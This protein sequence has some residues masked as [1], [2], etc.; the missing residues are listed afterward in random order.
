M[1]DFPM[2][3]GASGMFGKSKAG[4][5]TEDMLKNLKS[6]EKVALNI[7]KI[8][9]RI[10]GKQGGIGSSGG[11]SGDVGAQMNQMMNR[12]TQMTTSP[13][14]GL[15]R[16]LTAGKYMAAAGAVGYGMLPSTTDAVAQRISAQSVASLSGGRFNAQQVIAG[17]NQM[18]AG[19]MTGAYSAQNT[20]AL[21]TGNG[22]IAG[23]TGYGNIMR[24]VGGESAL[25]GM[26][27]EQVG[28]AWAS[29]NG[30]S[31]LSVGVRLRDATGNIRNTADISNDLYRRI[32]GNR[33]LTAEQ[34]AQALNPNSHTYQSILR[35]AGGN[36]QLAQMLATNI[37][38]QG[39]HGGKRLP[40][41]SPDAIRNNILGLPKDDP[42]RAVSKFFGSEA[43]NLQ[44]NGNGL[45]GGYDKA[46]GIA[47]G[48]N[49]GFASLS[50]SVPAVANAFANL[51]GILETLP[52]AGNA[53]ATASGLLGAGMHAVGG[54]ASNALQLYAA[55]KVLK[56][57]G[58]SGG[59]GAAEAAV[60]ARA[61]S[62][63]AKAM[64]LGSKAM[65]L[66][67][68]KLLPGLGAAIDAWD[69]HNVG[70]NDSGFS[71][72]HML[73]A[74]LSGG[75]A[76]AVIGSV[77]PGFGTLAGAGVGSVLNM[78]N[79]A[80]SHAFGGDMSGPSVG[81]H[82]AGVAPSTATPGSNG[83]FRPA[84]GPNTAMYGQKPKNNSYWQWKGYHTG[85]DFGVHYKPVYSYKSGTVVGAGMNITG[86]NAYGNTIIVD[87]GGHQSLY[88]HLSAINVRKG[89]KVI[90][91][92]NI[93]TSG[94][95]GTGAAMG[96]HLHFEIRKGGNPI[97]PLSFL[98]GSGIA[99]GIANTVRGAANAVGNAISSATHTVANWFQ[100]NN[101]A[102]AFTKTSFH[103]SEHPAFTSGLGGVVGNKDTKT[104]SLMNIGG[105]M[106]AGSVGQNSGFGRPI[107]INMNVNIA[108]ATVKDATR[109]ARDVRTVL[110]KEL[111]NSKISSY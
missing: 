32:Y 43:R 54:M 89:Q 28:G 101:Q 80:L 88:A 27:N 109:L 1:A 87:H 104:T 7:E 110:E 8:F 34:A 16:A 13:P 51:K 40:L 74:G 103:A 93:G 70:R 105:D 23:S 86:G 66:G 107:T 108:Q 95:T 81:A 33:Q 76:G 75:T 26:S 106:G 55:G 11:L 48:L 30:M 36:Q 56:G 29:A 20:A 90:G 12:L 91:G 14:T 111:R 3:T 78:A 92:Q 52:G 58:F 97:N 41:E 60:G 53:G 71:F 102:S 68:G 77:V 2:D 25:T 100:G 94:Q 96:P 39:Q 65:K 62:M 57:M 98:S 22:I 17:S 24:T 59:A 18:L 46:L 82:R 99:S 21:L 9:A 47:T 61:A 10:S 73:G 6:V 15:D 69:T 63:G 38:Y 42:M 31:F 64:S 49:N 83:T 4:K 85:Q 37:A 67:G 50:E 79:Y 19:G 5:A 45:V 44:A 72:K 35:A 84:N